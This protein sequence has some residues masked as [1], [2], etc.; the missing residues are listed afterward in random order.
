ME[1]SSARSRASGRRAFPPR[2][3]QPKRFARCKP[4][5][6]PL[7]TSTASNRSSR[8]APWGDAGSKN[9][10]PGRPNKPGVRPP[11]GASGASCVG[12]RATL[13]AGGGRSVAQRT[14]WR[15]FRLDERGG[16]ER[17]DEAGIV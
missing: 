14:D 17:G 8:K 7:R 16:V 3:R 12:G 9:F 13:N 2:P 10:M 4:T 5:H 15:G 6:P 11:P 1:D